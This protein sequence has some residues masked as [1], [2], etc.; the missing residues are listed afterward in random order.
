MAKITVLDNAGNKLGTFPAE[1]WEF[2]TTLAEKND[3]AIPKSCWMGA[4][5][6]CL[7][8]IVEWIDYVDKWNWFMA[9][10]DNQVLTCIAKVKDEYIN[11]DVNIIIK[12]VY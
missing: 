4:C 12:R 9:L 3:V 8:E 1:K 6:M 11:E 2:I 10:E 5:G 7:C